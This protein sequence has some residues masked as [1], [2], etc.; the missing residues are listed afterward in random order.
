MRIDKLLSNLNYGSRKDIKMAIKKGDVTVNEELV[1]T[2]KQHVSPSEDRI[3]FKG[4][5]IFYDPS[6]VL[7]MNKALHTVCANNDPLYPTVFDALEDRL[8]RLNLTTIGRLDQDTTGLLLL[9]NDGMLL[10]HVI[11]PKNRVYKVYEVTIDAPLDD[12]EM[13]SGNYTLYDDRDRP[14]TPQDVIVEEVTNTVLKISIHEGKHHQ[15]KEMIKHFNR[16]VVV[17]KRIQ[18]GNLVLDPSLQPSEVKVLTKKE[19]KLLFD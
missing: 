10:H 15:I 6:I 16:E 3:V 17:L 8:K 13:L 4:E 2:P 9:T 19:R 1:T 5:T 14:Y 11:S 18:I 12:V 7:M